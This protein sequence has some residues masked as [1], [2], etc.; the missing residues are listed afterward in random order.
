M[1]KSGLPCA[2]LFALLLAFAQLSAQPLELEWLE[3]TRSPKDRL[4]E[5][6]LRVDARNFYLLRS[7]IPENDRVARRIPFLEIL[8][9]E[10]NRLHELRLPLPENSTY[11][12]APAN[13]SCLL[14][15]WHE[16]ASVRARRFDF[17]AK[18]WAGEPLELFQTKAPNP[19]VWF[20]R[21]SDGSHTCVFFV[22]RRAGQNRME[23]AVFDR[24]LTKMWQKSTELPGDPATFEARDFFVSRTGAVCL[25][26]RVY[27]RPNWGFAKPFGGATS[28]FPD[29]RLPANE[30][31]AESVAPFSLAVFV[32]TNDKAQPLAFY[33][34]TGKKHPASVVFTDNVGGQ[35]YLAGFG[36]DAS[37]AIWENYFAYQISPETGGGRMLRQAPLP[38]PVR[39]AMLSDKAHERKE[40]IE[41]YALRSADWAADGRLWL[42]AEREKLSLFPPNRLEDAVV[43]KFDSAFQI[44]AT[45]VV[46]KGQNLP[47]GNDPF[48]AS[49]AKIGMPDGGFCLLWNDGKWPNTSFRVAKMKRTGSPEESDLDFAQRSGV[50]P[51]PCTLREWNGQWYFVAESEYREKFRIGVLRK[52][53]GKK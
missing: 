23:V 6:L 36:G 5:Q 50:S 27:D 52:T 42:F 34:E 17:V 33:P 29:G 53:K 3:K 37:N 16:S 51:L 43:F 4:T 20:S 7:Q 41:N 38:N 40:P 1:K 18:K 11:L 22:D 47:G 25:L 2:P 13:D 32:L 24:R 48:V 35:V 30:Y 31:L 39:R 28:Y 12:C 8:T 49:F 45:R 10:G 21:A 44:T 26:A 9:N 15:V 14:L 19:E 46:G